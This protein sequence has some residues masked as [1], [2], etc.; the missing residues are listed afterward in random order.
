MQFQLHSNFTSL[1]VGRL[2]QIGLVKGL[3][4][5]VRDYVFK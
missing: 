4:V 1:L 2:T 5:F 3:K